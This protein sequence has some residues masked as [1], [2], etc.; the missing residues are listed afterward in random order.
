M[1]KYRA[2][3]ITLLSFGALLMVLAALANGESP[4][5]KPSVPGMVGGTGSSFE[6]TDSQ[7]LNVSL[8]STEEITVS[9]ESVP[10]TISLDIGASTSTD[11]AVLTIGDLELNT[12]YHQF[13]DNYRNKAVFVSD[14][15]G[16]YAWTQDLTQPHHVWIQET[17]GTVFIPDQCSAYG[18]WDAA[19]STCTLT[20]DL[21]ESVEITADSV[22]LDCNGHTIAGNDTGYG[23]LLS[24]KTNIT[25]KNC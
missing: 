22:V 20:Q 9:L 12:T 19:A 1:K 18:V 10:K 23:I 13:Q 21:T 17:G 3:T 16:S 2:I 11:S 15:K 6:I 8:R 7:Y 5:S 4:E 14:E 24:G 25:S